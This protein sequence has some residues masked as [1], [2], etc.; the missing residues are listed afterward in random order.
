MCRNLET[1]R[2]HC[3]L[4]AGEAELLKSPAAP[5]VLLQK[6]EEDSLPQEL[7]PSL[8][9]LGIMLPYTPLHLLLIQE[10]PPELVMTSGNRSG[11]PLIISNREALEELGSIA[12]FP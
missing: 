1:V 8:N 7:A 6:R 2:H 5:I 12:D 4:T 10:G 11:L 9:T 3:Y